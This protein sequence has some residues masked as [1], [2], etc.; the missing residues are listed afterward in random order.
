MDTEDTLRALNKTQLIE[1]FLK[2]QEYT[3]G[4]INSLIE[5][6]KNLNENF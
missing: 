2:S 1:L 3:K 5:E 4:I 6:I